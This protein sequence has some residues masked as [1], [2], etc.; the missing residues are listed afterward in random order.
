MEPPS[1]SRKRYPCEHCNEICSS[2]YNL[3]RH[4]ARRHIEML[5]D[6]LRKKRTSSNIPLSFVLPQSIGAFQTAANNVNTQF[7]GMHVLFVD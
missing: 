6:V 7:K 2:N 3:E 5:P 1:K 4:V